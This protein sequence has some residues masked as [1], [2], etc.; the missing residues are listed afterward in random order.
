MTI[1]IKDQTLLASSEL[2]RLVLSTAEICGIEDQTG[3]RRTNF[4]YSSEYFV[5][6]NLSPTGRIWI[7]ISPVDDG[8]IGEGT[9]LIEGDELGMTC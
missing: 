6:L 8:D 5:P 9:H 1:L 4:T 7:A 2:A 3:K